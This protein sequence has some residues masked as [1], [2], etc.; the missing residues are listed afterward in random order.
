MPNSAK[1]VAL[2]QKINDMVED[3]L[4]NDLD[5]A[6]TISSDVVFT[7]NDESGIKITIDI[8]KFKHQ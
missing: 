5:Q 6:T 4:D 2:Y 1:N 3:F 7:L 8:S